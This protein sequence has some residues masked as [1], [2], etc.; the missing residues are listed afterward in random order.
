[1]FD[2]LSEFGGKAATAA[3]AGALYGEDPKLARDVLRGDMLRRD[4]PKRTP[5]GDI[6]A[7]IAERLFGFGALAADARDR[8]IDATLALYAKDA[9]E[10][11]DASGALN[12]R[13]L[14][15]ALQRA[16]DGLMSVDS[17]ANALHL[18]SAGAD[19][20]LLKRM[21]AP[22]VDARPDLA[23]PIADIL[24]AGPDDPKRLA[25]RIMKG[26]IG[27]AFTVALEVVRAL[28]KVLNPDK[29]SA[30]SDDK[31][32]EESEADQTSKN[33]GAE[34]SEEQSQPSQFESPTLQIVEAWPPLP[35][36][37][38]GAARYRFIGNREFVARADG[39]FD[40]GAIPRPIA[41]AI[42]RD[43][44]PIR[45][46]KGKPNKTGELH[47]E[48]G[49]RLTQIQSAGYTDAAELVDDVGRTFNEVWPGEDE[50]LLLVK[51]GKEGVSPSMY[52]ELKRGPGSPFY[53]V[54]SGG[55]FRDDLIKKKHKAPLWQGER[56]SK[57]ATGEQEPL[58]T[59]PE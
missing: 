31:Q 24:A 47:M 30:P 46:P 17:E 55:V 14:D 51:R 13:R 40:F 8:I 39:S 4:N 53:E 58:P 37:A 59:T 16:A 54:K 35:P 2:K 29:T 19:D 20:D 7:A 33:N 41:D 1:V 11:G 56:T 44:A 25:R 21:L 10:R 5:E 43:A 12:E 42:G 18:V 26:R 50:T 48:R 34:V 52:I 9:A 49:G 22:L 3:A 6:E 23:G 57:T 15:A 38:T 36:I 28:R 32:T 27:A 45:L